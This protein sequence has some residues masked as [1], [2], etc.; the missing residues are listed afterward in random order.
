[1][2]VA[3]VLQMTYCNAPFFVLM[4]HRLLQHENFNVAYNVVRNM[5]LLQTFWGRQAAYVAM[6]AKSGSRLNVEDDMTCASPY[7]E[8]RISTPV[9]LNVCFTLLLYK[10][11]H[12]QFLPNNDNK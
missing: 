1:M 12:C 3:H 9:V 11:K 4:G 6:K 10:P 7:S 2:L 8:L 5:Q